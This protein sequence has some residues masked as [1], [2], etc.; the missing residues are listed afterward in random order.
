MMMMMM[1]VMMMIWD[2]KQ[3]SCSS[4][5]LLHKQ[6]T[7]V[8]I[9]IFSIDFQTLICPSSTT[10]QLCDPRHSISPVWPIFFLFFYFFIYRE[11]GVVCSG[12]GVPCWLLSLSAVCPWASNST[13]QSLSLFICKMEMKI[14]TLSLGHFRE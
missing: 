14:V 7:C 5:F 10:N 9:L 13:P 6:C 8:P 3:Q 1:I 11:C 12:A 2:W 4:P